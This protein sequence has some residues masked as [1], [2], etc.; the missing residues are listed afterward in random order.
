[1]RRLFILSVVLSGAAWAQQLNLDA[2][3][4]VVT[5]AR[6]V[7]LVPTDVTFMINVSA[8][9]AIPI[10]QVL[11][12][13]DFGLTTN[14]LTNIGSYP[15]GPVYGPPDPS[16]IT[17]TFRLAVAVA[18]MKDTLAKL[19]NLRKTSPT[20]IDLS[21][22]TAGF[23]PSQTAVLAARDKALPDLMTDARNRAQSIANAAGLKLGAIQ[24]VNDSYAYPSG[25]NC[26][27]QP[28][29]TF[30]AIVRFAA[31]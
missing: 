12:A 24:A 11:A 14:D 2:N 3:S 30:S 7:V 19:D 23:G 31:Q 22:S 20:G 15:I 1:M 13:V 4:I 16:R 26:P 29:V 28:I 27:A 9:V 21:Y 25:Y 10:D 5:A 8:D 6:T 17:Y 18:Q